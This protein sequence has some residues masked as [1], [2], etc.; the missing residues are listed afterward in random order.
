MLHRSLTDEVDRL[1]V[2]VQ[3][4]SRDKAERDVEIGEALTKVHALEDKV[5]TQKEVITE[6]AD[7]IRGIEVGMKLL[8]KF[9]ISQLH[10]LRKKRASVCLGDL[11]LP[12]LLELC[13]TLQI[14]TLLSRP[15]YVKLRQEQTS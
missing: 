9:N 1:R 6:Q 12:F 5:D 15:H 14:I 4:L 2:Q 13:A 3:Q 11:L 8:S 10:R 7:R